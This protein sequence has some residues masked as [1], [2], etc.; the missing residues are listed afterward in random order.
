MNATEA[1][2]K[3]KQELVRLPSEIREGLEEA[4]RVVEQ[5]VQSVEQD[6]SFG[7]DNPQAEPANQSNDA[8]AA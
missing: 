1:F 8:P 6:K 3:V 2:A 7:E 5:A 4:V